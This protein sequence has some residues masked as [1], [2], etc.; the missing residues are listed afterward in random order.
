[1]RRRCKTERETVGKRPKGPGT[2]ARRGSQVVLNA[3]NCDEER[4]AL[5]C[6]QLRR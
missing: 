1:M 2:P 3:A 5:T 6:E 4:T